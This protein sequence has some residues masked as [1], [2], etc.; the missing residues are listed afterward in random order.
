MLSVIE[1]VRFVQFKIHHDDHNNKKTTR[2]DID[3]R[4]HKGRCHNEG[5]NERLH[6]AKR[7]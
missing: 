1:N 3:N 4:S 6:K 2:K 5:N 7:G